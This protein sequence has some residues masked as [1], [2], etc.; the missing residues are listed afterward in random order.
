MKRTFSIIT[1][2]ISLS[3]IGIIVIQVSWIKNMVMLREEQI[4][5]SVEDAASMVADELKEHKGSY[6]AGNTKRGLLT[7]EFVLDFSKPLNIG[8]RVD[9]DEVK[10]KLV[11]AFL[12]NDL[13]DIRFEFGIASFDNNDNT[14]F[15]KVT[16]NFMT[17]FE[18]T[19]TTILNTLVWKR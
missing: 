8:Q 6:A 18:D 1:I 5:H 16:P 10:K 11:K 12:A 17:F 15:E 7:D 13:K 19:Y 2:L 4:K 14:V 9:M 3:L